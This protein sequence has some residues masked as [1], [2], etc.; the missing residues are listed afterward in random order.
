MIHE[1]KA[2]IMFGS[3]DEQ[4]IGQGQVSAIW[5]RLVQYAGVFLVTAVLFGGLYLGI[6]FLE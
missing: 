2:N 4:T 1:R 3:L 5:A 6:R